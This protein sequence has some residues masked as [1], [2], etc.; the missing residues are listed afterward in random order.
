MGRLGPKRSTRVNPSGRCTYV[1]RPSDRDRRLDAGVRVVVLHR[2]V[3]E[4]E[5]VDLGDGGVEPEGRQ[6]TRLACQLQVRLLDVVGVEVTVTTRPH[7][8]T[9]AKPGYLGDHVRKQRVGCDVERH[10]QKD[11]C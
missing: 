2:D 11:V 9:H 10:S 5:L 7:E 6:R 8:V 1:V 3:V 4:F